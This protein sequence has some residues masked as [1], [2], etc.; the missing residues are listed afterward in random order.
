M[1]RRGQKI[2][3]RCDFGVSD[4]CR[5]SYQI[6]RRAAA[7]NRKR[8]DGALICLYCSRTLKFSGRNNPNVKYK[9]LDDSFFNTIETE[10][11]AYWLGWI[12]SDGSVREDRI[13]LA[14][15]SR[16]RV[17]LERLRAIICDELPIRSI[18]NGDMVSLTISSSEMVRDVCRWLDIEPGPK[19]ERVGFPDLAS[20]ALRWTFLRGFFDGDGS[21]SAPDGEGSPR[22]SITTSS[23]R[24]REAI[25]DVTSTTYYHDPNE[26]RLE[27]NGNNALDFLRRLYDGASY[28]LPR[29]YDRYV[30]WSL[31][32]PAL[33]GG[34]RYGRELHFRWSKTREDAVPPFKKRASDSGYDL[35]LV[36]KVKEAGRVEFFTTGVKVRPAYGWYFDLVPRSSISKTGYVMAN[37]VGVI[38]RTYTGPILVALMKAD[39]D[40]PAIELPARIVQLVPRPIVHTEFEEVDT[41]DATERG[42]GGFGSTD[43]E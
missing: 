14:I 21:I 28:R 29:K 26:G 43:R 9:S 1:R 15:Q 2:T 16:D 20:D 27:W 22:C 25:M 41:L 30:D 4:R 12:A 3:V 5:G 42:S 18:R 32:V 17:L 19:S 6:S 38:D 37:S 24:M 34:G 36:D 33:S 10:G 40:A 23:S 35:T 39:P 8:N 31:W 11:Q 7:K 13:Q